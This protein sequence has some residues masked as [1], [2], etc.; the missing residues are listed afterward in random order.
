MRVLIAHNRYFLRGGADRV[1][2]QTASL[3][4]NRG[5]TVIPFSMKDERNLPTI[6]EKYFVEKLDYSKIGPSFKNLDT[7]LK[8]IYSKEAKKKIE[9]LIK[10][11]KPD[12]AHLH[13]IYGGI[14]PSIVALLKKH[15][16]PIVMTLHDYK[17]ICPSYSISNN[18]K[19]C[20]KCKGG[21]FYNAVFSKCHK[22]SYLA[23]LVYSTEALIH[24]FLKSYDN[25]DYFIAPSIFLKRKM[26]EFG[27]AEERIE[28]IP[29][30][31]DVKAVNPFFESK[32]YFLY[33]GQL[34]RAKGLFTLLETVRHL[35]KHYSL[36]IAGDGEQKNKLIEFAK[37]KKIENIR[38]LGHIK[39][40]DLFKVISEAMFI[41]LPSECYEN[42]PLS[43]LE[44]F[45]YGKPVIG[46][47]IGGIP[48]LISAGETGLLFEPGNYEDLG[49]KINYLL[50]NPSKIIEMGKKARKR[51]E[52]EYNPEKYYQRLM[53]IYQLASG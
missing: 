10:D 28:Y 22:N 49:K 8:M 26:C 23:S 39:G 4:E 15:N 47:N 14:T 32:N 48:E 42:A 24:T 33:T 36:Y 30:F 11:T 2:F 3:L 27:I 37:E 19:P 1:F 29:N 51:A 43:I 45:V 53:A 38:F 25:I 21:K 20:E 9:Q 52:E 13:N 16:V 41:V 31:V 7:A 12:I 50:K 40:E 6:Y 17:L 44:A 34:L 46:S 5:H 18:G 35:D